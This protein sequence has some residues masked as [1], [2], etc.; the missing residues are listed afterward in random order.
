MMLGLGFVGDSRRSM[1]GSGVSW[2]LAK[3]VEVLISGHFW[4]DNRGQK[5]IIVYFVS[6]TH[7]AS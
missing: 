7:L 2:T 4:Y 3:I 6:I 5:G 1:R